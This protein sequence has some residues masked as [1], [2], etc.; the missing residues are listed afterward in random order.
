M[1]RLA[2]FNKQVK[3]KFG[4]HA[5]A[6]F[7]VLTA[8]QFHLLFYSSRPLPNIFALALGKHS[9]H[10]ISIYI[11]NYEICFY[12]VIGMNENLIRSLQKEKCNSSVVY[13]L[14]STWH[15]L[16]GLREATCVHYKPWYALP[17]M[18]SLNLNVA[19]FTLL[20]KI[21]LFPNF[22]M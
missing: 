9:A 13:V 19:V 6:F 3:K 15:T 7:V 20:L 18:Y 10:C 1:V 2:Y 16:Y 8:I 4:H 12:Q 22:V 17:W 11:N 14:Q 21:G 5:E